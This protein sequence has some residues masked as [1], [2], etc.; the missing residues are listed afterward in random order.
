MAN[1]VENSCKAKE[2]PVIVIH[3]CSGGYS[4][5]DVS[6]TERVVESGMSGAGVHQ[7]GKSKLADSSESL[8][9]GS[10]D[11][12]PL[13]G[14]EVDVSMNRIANVIGR[15]VAAGSDHGVCLSYGTTTKWRRR[16][17]A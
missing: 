12:M 2:S 7:R 17:I 11:D 6:D 13:V 8:K 3:V 15:Q 9:Q 14:V 16:S 4:R 10:V 5:G 1:V